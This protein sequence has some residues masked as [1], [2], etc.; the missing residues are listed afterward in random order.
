MKNFIW[1][2]FAAL[3]LSPGFTVPQQRT[4]TGIVTSADD[5]NGMPG[6]SVTLKGT[7]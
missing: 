7:S 4:I 6:V 5:G 3:V 2:L 1:I